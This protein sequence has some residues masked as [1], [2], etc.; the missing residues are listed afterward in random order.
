MTGPWH[1][2]WTDDL[3]FSLRNLWFHEDDTGFMH[4]LSCLPSLV[5]NQWVTKN[6]NCYRNVSLE[7]IFVLVRRI[8]VEIWLKLL[9]LKRWGR[10]SLE[11]DSRE[12]K[13]MGD[14][15]CI[16]YLGKARN[17]NPLVITKCPVMGL[18]LWWLLE[19]WKLLYCDLLFHSGL[20]ALVCVVYL[21]HDWNC[22]NSQLFCFH[23]L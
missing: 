6:Q 17:L 19:R 21:L 13:E 11:K 12:P 3:V 16:K 4:D 15:F 23:C 22:S 5:W 7:D 20:P 14:L 2:R 10:V 1:E 9:C 18:F 8:F